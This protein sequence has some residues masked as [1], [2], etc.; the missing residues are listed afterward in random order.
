MSENL[1]IESARQ[2]GAAAF[3]LG[4]GI[5]RNPYKSRR[6]FGPAFKNAWRDG[7][8]QASR[9]SVALENADACAAGHDFVMGALGDVDADGCSRCDVVRF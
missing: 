4:Q 5:E 2:R 6:G 7:W 8:R 1:S 9:A 3:A